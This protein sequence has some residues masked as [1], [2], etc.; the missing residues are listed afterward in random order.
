[1]TFPNHPPPPAAA[2]PLIV[3]PEQV[4]ERRGAVAFLSHTTRNGD[5]AL[6]RLFRT[7]A[8]MG[9]VELDLTRAQ[10]SADTSQIEIAAILGNVTVLVPPELRL[11]C[12]VDTFMGSCEVKRRAASTALP[13]A[14][15]LR[16]TGTAVMSSV[17][18]KVVDPNAPGWVDRLLGRRS[19]AGQ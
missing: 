2:G 8:F 3:S 18:V 9:N 15:L 1:V 5:W 14:P 13:G 16:I 7:V 4:P 6:P 12:D 17:E 10:V 11:E 19:P